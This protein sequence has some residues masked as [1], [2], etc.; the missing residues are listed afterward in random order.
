[1]GVGTASDQSPL[2]KTSRRL[3]LRRV[4][5]TAS[6]QKRRPGEV[7]DAIFSVLTARPGGASLQVIEQY[8]ADLIE[9]E[10][11]RVSDPI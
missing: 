7:R 3:I 2:T 6:Q 1:M 8:V 11:D 5:K 9:M 10:R 4:Y